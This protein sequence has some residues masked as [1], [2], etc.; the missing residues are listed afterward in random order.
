MRSQIRLAQ[1]QPMTGATT[2]ARAYQ[3]QKPL[4][5]ILSRKSTARTAIASSRAVARAPARLSSRRA[6]V[7]RIWKTRSQIS[8]PGRNSRPHSTMTAL[9]QLSRS[10]RMRCAARLCSTTTCGWVPKDWMSG[11]RLGPS[12]RSMIARE[13]A[14]PRLG[15]K[16]LIRGLLTADLCHSLLAFS[17]SSASLSR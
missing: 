13:N 9:S 3:A 7:V 17:I 15:R 12:I 4:K 8:S 14:S 16:S 10:L 2:Q 11:A 5:G 6:T 1:N